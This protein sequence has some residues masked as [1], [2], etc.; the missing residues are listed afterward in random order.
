[1]KVL[2]LSLFSV[3]QCVGGVILLQWPFG[4]LLAY[5]ALFGMFS[6]LNEICHSN[7]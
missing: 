1:M 6:H 4:Y 7:E 3:C 5:E 2:N